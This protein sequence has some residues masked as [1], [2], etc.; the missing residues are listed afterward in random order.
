MQFHFKIYNTL[1]VV[2]SAIL[3]VNGSKTVLNE[4]RFYEMC[5]LCVGF[6]FLLKPFVFTVLL[7]HFSCL[8]Y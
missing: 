8:E 5:W 4:L 3:L 6:C 1:C 2:F 7:L